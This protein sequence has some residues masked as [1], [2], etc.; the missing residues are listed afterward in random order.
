[1]Q[2]YVHKAK[3]LYYRHREHWLT[4]AFFLG[5]VVDNLTLNRVDQW[6]DILILLFY[7]LLAMASMFFLYAASAERLPE[8][9][10]TFVRKY[11]P[12]AA[13]YAYGGL[14]SGMLIFY[15]R[16]G[17][18]LE[19]WPFLLLIL[20]VIYGNETIRDRT[21][22]LLF[23]LSMLFIGLFSYV[24]LVVPVIIGHMGA[25]IFLGSG[26]LAALVMYG[27]VQLL[28]LVIPRFIDLHMRSLVFTLGTIF[29]TFNFLYFTNIIPPIP[30]SLKDVGIYHS[31]LRI[32]VDGYQEYELKYEKPHWW[33]FFRDSDKV[34][35]YESGDQIFC[36]ASVFAPTRLSTEIYHR[37]EKYDEEKGAWVEHARLSYSI[38]GGRGGGFRGYTLIKNYSEGTW[39]CTVETG[40][41][42]VLGSEKFKVESGPKG[43]LVTRVE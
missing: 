23:T 14:F 37:W 20:G 36:F 1:M 25:G 40:R 16:S 41:G 22:R 27:F 17:S 10:T 24:V 2:A 30:L 19:S 28:R 9:M 12:L 18:W 35:H 7:V 21:S 31:V 13:Q 3:S 32:E 26:V 5:F 8:R 11:A 42:Q 15:S 38:S 33:Q 43:E 4:I 34:F 6:F 29:I 39:R